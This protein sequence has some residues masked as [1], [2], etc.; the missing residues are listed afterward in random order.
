MT[1]L[2]T[3]RPRLLPELSFPAYAYLPGRQP[4]P[5]RDQGGHSYGVETPILPLEQALLSDEFDWGIDLFN[6]GYYWEAHEAWESLWHASKGHSH[7]R[8]FFKSLILLSAAGVKIREG[9]RPAAS[10][11]AARAA[12][13]LRRLP[14]GSDQLVNGLVGMHPAILAA[15]AENAA[16]SAVYGTLATRAPESV[17]AFLL[18]H[19]SSKN[20]HTP[21]NGLHGEEDHP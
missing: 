3:S 6:H 18:W 8:L 15:R 1:P 17:F 20:G 13:T 12:M 7:Y 19:V 21:D 14:P 2:P 16:A 9:K 5:V 4:H 11:H 10:R